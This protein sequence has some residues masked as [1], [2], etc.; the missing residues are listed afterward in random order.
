MSNIEDDIKNLKEITELLKE[1]IN[2]KDENATAVLDIYDIISLNNILADRERLIQKNEE[3]EAKLEFKQFGDLDN[4]QFE[5]YLQEVDKELIV[6]G[7]IYDNP[8]LLESE[9]K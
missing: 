9:G 2:S 6:I 8:E 7:N 5:Q 1:E 4:A 3:L